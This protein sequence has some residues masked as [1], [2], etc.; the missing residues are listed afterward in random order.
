MRISKRSFCVWAVTLPLVVLPIPARAGEPASSAPTLTDSLNDAEL[1]QLVVDLGDPSFAKRNLATRRLVSAGMKAY[2]ALAEVAKSDDLERAL[3]AKRIVE[4]LD[5]IYFAG[6][7]I[8][9]SFESSQARWDQPVDLVVE[10]HNRA[11]FAAIVPFEIAPVMP[12]VPREE[13]DRRKVDSQ[14]QPGGRGGRPGENGDDDIFADPAGQASRAVPA[15]SADARQ[16]ADMLDVA[17]WLKVLGPDGKAVDLRVDD[18]AA[19]PQVM[20]AVQDRL[21]SAPTSRLPAGATRKIIIRAFNRGWA[22]YPML[23]SGRYTT[24]LEYVPPWTDEALAEAQ[25]GRV[26]SNLAN[27]EVRESA[28]VEVSRSG[29]T[30]SVSLSREDE[31]LVAALTNHSELPIVVNLNFGPGPPFATAYWELHVGEDVHKVPVA[32]LNPTWKDFTA[33]RLAELGP[34]KSLE[35]ARIAAAEL[36]QELPDIAPGEN[37][38]AVSPPF[39]RFSY[40]NALDRAWQLRES[41]STLKDSSVPQVLREPL[42][43]QLLIMHPTSDPV[44][45]PW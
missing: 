18:I 45:A 3:R 19:D 6:C 23:E 35:L 20:A 39:V 1:A 8:R 12:P 38:P 42:P 21:E 34:G 31:F 29:S 5:S 36:R 22:R 25:I 13:S 44:L 41:M 32:R 37:A 10:I 2:E 14:P 16:V 27:I 11:P 40:M 9:L 4:T 26:V 15:A 30:A 17:E 24:I 7:D 43:R 28:P 33:T